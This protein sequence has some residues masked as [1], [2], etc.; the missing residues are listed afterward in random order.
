MVAI[1]TS[2]VTVPSPPVTLPPAAPTASADAPASASDPV[3]TVTLSPEAQQA[4]AAKAAPKG[5]PSQTDTAAA[6][7]A[8]NDTSG[9]TSLDDQLKA[10]ALLAQ[11]VA[12]G[13]V[14]SGRY[15]AS[16]SDGSAA[17]ASGGVVTADAAA[18]LIGSA[19]AQHADAVAATVDQAKDPGPLT[20]GDVRAAAL[21]RGLAAFDRLTAADQQV[22][23]AVQNAQAALSGGPQIASVD[24]YRASQQAAAAAARADTAP[25]AGGSS[26]TNT[27]APAA[28]TPPD[29]KTLMDALAR[30]DDTAGVVSAADL[31]AAKQ[32][33]DAYAASKPTGLGAQAVIQNAA[34][35]PYALRASNDQ[36]LV[37]TYIVPGKDPFPQ[38]LAN[39]NALSPEDQQ[40]YWGAN[41]VAP[42]GSKRFASVATLKQ[43]LTV[44]ETMLRLY[45]GVTQAY[46]VG[47]LSELTDLPSKNNPAL[48]QLQN[49]YRMDQSSDGWTSMAQAFLNNVTPADLGLTPVDDDGT[50]DM[51]KALETLQAV[52]DDAKAF[53][54]AVKDG[55]VTQYISATLAK[56]AQAQADAKTAA[57]T[58]HVLDVAA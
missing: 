39:L 45:R 1:S 14:I 10:Y 13:Q 6:A 24:A 29:A 55:K 37:E 51:A 52:A 53:T 3:D 20:A 25:P 12:K 35:S 49:L 48:Q 11:A 2:T 47:D 33:I 23:L 5:P 31:V 44:R 57:Q 50:A 38:M 18:A 15:L 8:L 21:E 9:Q 43:N 54:K 22:Y 28:Y 36:K 16:T 19:F 32:L 40:A 34:A 42:D 46:G 56:Q 30:L 41:N 17:A 4:L 26:A 27:T 58:G 7:A